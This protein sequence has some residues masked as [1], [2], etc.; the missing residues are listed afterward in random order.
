M[1]TKKPQE[2]SIYL[3]FNPNDTCIIKITSYIFS[4]KKKTHIKGVS[5]RR[6]GI[7]PPTFWEETK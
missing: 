5:E 3:N 4:P 7:L 6:L 1:L 2:L